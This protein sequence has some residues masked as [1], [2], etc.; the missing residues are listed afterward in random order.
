MIY[1]LMQNEHL[2]DVEKLQQEWQSEN[3]TY[4]L[5]AGTI[6]Q[7]SEAMTPYCLIAKDG[8]KIIGYLMAKIKNDNEYCV[9]PNGVTFIDVTDLFVTSAYRS[10]GIGK[11]LLNQCEKITRKN[12]I[13]YVLLSSATKDAEAIRKFYTGNGYTIWTTQFFKIVE[14]EVKNKW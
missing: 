12:G 7:I 10:R 6:N 8:E 11:E 4:G 2:I 13:K 14:L 5:V 1:E 9:F 3:I